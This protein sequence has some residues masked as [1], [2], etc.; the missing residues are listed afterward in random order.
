[1]Y[2]FDRFTYVY[3]MYY[4]GIAYRLGSTN[5]R[6]HFEHTMKTTDHD[7]LKMAETTLRNHIVP[8]EKPDI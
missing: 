6:V 5:V 7:I 4:L 2:I 1:M 3:V 8:I